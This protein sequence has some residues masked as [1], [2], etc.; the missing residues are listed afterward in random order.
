MSINLL[1]RATNAVDE[2]IREKFAVH[3]VRTATT[4]GRERLSY[5]VTDE[6]QGKTFTVTI[7]EGISE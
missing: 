6:S 1:R 2:A 3:Y 7:E 5:V 4:L